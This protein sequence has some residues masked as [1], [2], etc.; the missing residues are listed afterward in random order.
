MHRQSV[1]RMCGGVKIRFKTEC[2]NSI[3]DA[4]ATNKEINEYY[5]TLLYSHNTQTTYKFKM[6]SV[7]SPIA[8]S[9]RN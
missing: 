7:S 4:K 9:E 5:C 1:I 3:R 8:Q 2:M 6:I